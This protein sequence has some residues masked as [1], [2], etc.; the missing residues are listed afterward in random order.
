MFVSAL[1]SCTLLLVLVC[2]IP[3]MVHS[4]NHQHDN[5]ERFSTVRHLI[6][7]PKTFTEDNNNRHLFHWQPVMN[8]AVA[9]SAGEINVP[10]KQNKKRQRRTH[11]RR[12][13]MNDL[14][15]QTNE[16][17]THKQDRRINR[18]DKKQNSQATRKRKELLRS[19]ENYIPM[20]FESTAMLERKIKE[21]KKK[22]LSKTKAMTSGGNVVD[23]I[24]VK[25]SEQQL[26]LDNRVMESVRNDSHAEHCHCEHI[27]LQSNTQC[28]CFNGFR[29]RNDGRTCKDINECKENK[30]LCSH[31][32]QNLPGSYRCLCPDGYRPDGNVCRD[33]NE[34]LL[35]NGHGPC[36][37]TCINT[38]GAYMCT[39]ARLPGT[40]LASN[41]RSCVSV[42]TVCSHMEGCSHEC[43]SVRGRAYCLCPATMQLGMD[44]KTCEH[45]MEYQESSNLT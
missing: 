34:C 32:C 23:R 42:N 45:S 31:E 18:K 20:N 10:A 33:V 25:V 9:T 15:L 1:Y 16:E 41:G 40:R 36:Q 12:Q 14:L 30:R 17:L 6:A 8:T 28:D 22:K 4:T 11:R 13:L 24:D 29:L 39:C 21:K 27:C 43:V 19:K 2:F 38:V 7:K 3:L 26:E 37:D 5:N 44:W 35:N